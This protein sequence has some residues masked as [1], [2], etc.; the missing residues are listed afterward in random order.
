[1][2]SLSSIGQGL[3]QYFQ[4]LVGTQ[5]TSS[6]QNSQAVG[7]TSDTSSSASQAVS[8]SH[9]HHHGGGHGGFSKI[10]SAVTSALQSAQSNGDT[11]DPNTI[12]QSAIA[13]VLGGSQATGANATTGTA[14]AQPTATDS[15]GDTDFSPSEFLQTLQSH[16]VDPQQFRQDFISALQTTNSGDTD[17][18]GISQFLPPGILVDTTG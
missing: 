5:A 16:G 7:A 14:T 9:H 6:T 10:A 8:G 17:N 1:M 13:K 4:S 12:I 3:A 15:D 11:E 18:T 2:S